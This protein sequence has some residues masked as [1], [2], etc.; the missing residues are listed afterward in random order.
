MVTMPLVKVVVVFLMG[1]VALEAFS[2]IFEDFLETLVEE[3]LD[4]QQQRGQD[5]KY[6]VE[7]DLRKRMR[8]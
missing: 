2:D 6:E 4:K 5:L 3:A 1:S 8:V 7:V